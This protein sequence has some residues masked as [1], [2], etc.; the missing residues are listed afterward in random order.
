MRDQILLET[1]G[2]KPGAPHRTP[3]GGKKVG[4]TFWMVSNHGD[5]SDYVR[6]IKAKPAARVHIGNQWH[7]GVAHLMPEDDAVARLATLP[8][9]N[10]AM[11][12]AFGTNLLTIRIDFAG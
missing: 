12:R 3:V 7:D 5:Q 10:S 9:M 2:R 6:N 1:T 11:V 8:G 4:A